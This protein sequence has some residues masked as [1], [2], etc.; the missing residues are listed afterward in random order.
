MT[1]ATLHAVKGGK[2]VGAYDKDA[3][4]VDISPPMKCTLLMFDYFAGCHSVP[5]VIEKIG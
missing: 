2:M 3:E 5:S 1:G 4:S